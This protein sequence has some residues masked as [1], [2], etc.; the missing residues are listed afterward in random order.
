MRTTPKKKLICQLQCLTIRLAES[1]CKSCTI[2]VFLGV[3]STAGL[4]ILIFQKVMR[5]P[6]KKEV[7]IQPK[8]RSL[9]IQPTINSNRWSETKVPI[10]TLRG[11]WLEQLGF[12]PEKR[13]K[14]ITSE[15]TLIIHLDED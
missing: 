12:S 14:V 10:I 4:L 8:V 11:L 7:S 1:R 2:Q 6:E 15:K 13:V 9:K 3:R 5:T